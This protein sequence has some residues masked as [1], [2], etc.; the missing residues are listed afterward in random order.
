MYKIANAF[1]SK[2]P[3]RLQGKLLKAIHLYV[4]HF[5]LLAATAY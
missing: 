5:Y 1:L 2:R 4:L 3:N